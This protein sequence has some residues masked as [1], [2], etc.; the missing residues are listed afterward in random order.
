MILQGILFGMGWLTLGVIL[1]FFLWGLADGTVSAGNMLLWAV[2]IAVPSAI[3][4]GATTLR[5]KGRHGAAMGLASLLAV[6]AL[7]AG[8]VI[9]VLI[10][11]PPRW[12]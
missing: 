9:L 1:L 11:A 7:L 5:A 10:V 8:I 12:N 2:L 6:P 3:L 4:W